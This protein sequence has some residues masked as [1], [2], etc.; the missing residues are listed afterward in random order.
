MPPVDAAVV[1]AH[2]GSKSRQSLRFAARC[3]GAGA[4]VP[5]A[6]DGTLPIAGDAVPQSQVTIMVQV[7][8][9]RLSHSDWLVVSQQFGL[10][11]GDGHQGPAVKWLATPLLINSRQELERGAAVETCDAYTSANGLYELSPGHPRFLLLR[12]EFLFLYTRRTRGA[13]VACFT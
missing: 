9:Q 12:P 11:E 5:I 6:Y 4:A 2:A 8:V 3:K 1:G 10:Q 13:A 7:Q